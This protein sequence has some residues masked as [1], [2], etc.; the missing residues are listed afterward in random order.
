MSDPCCNPNDTFWSDQLAA[1]KIS[2]AK[3]QA[4]I[5]ALTIGGM[6]NYRLSTGQTDQMVT[7]L[8]LPGLNTVLN[9]TLNRIATLQARLGGCGIT[10]VVPNS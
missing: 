1:A 2:A 8:N 9:S 3:I 7:K 6:S 4:A 10:H 5:D